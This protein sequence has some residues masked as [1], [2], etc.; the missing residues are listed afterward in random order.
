MLSACVQRVT[1]VGAAHGAELA[2]LAG[3]AL[4]TVGALASFALG[5]ALYALAGDPALALVAQSEH[6]ALDLV[7]V[8]IL[9]HDD[10]GVEVRSAQSLDQRVVRVTVNSGFSDNHVSRVARPTCL[11]G[12]LVYP[13]L[14]CHVC[15]IHPGI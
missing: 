7:S 13:T 11:P 14:A 6:A 8:T 10:P 12:T 9:V 5:L 2:G 4:A 1:V 15:K 3:I